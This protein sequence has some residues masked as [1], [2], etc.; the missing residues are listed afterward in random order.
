[1]D[2]LDLEKEKFTKELTNLDKHFQLIKKFNV[3]ENVKENAT[4]TASLKEQIDKAYDQL[5]SFNE[6]ETIFK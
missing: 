1:M 6:R 5:R 3:Y 4:E 2:V